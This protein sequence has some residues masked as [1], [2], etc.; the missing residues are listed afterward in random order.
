MRRSLLLWFGLLGAPAAW[1][2]QH[3]TGYALTEAACQEA[4]FDFPVDG[5]TIAVTAA[6]GVVAALAGVAAVATWR[7]TRDGGQR[8]ARKHFMATM[9]M[10]LTPLFLMIILMSGIGSVSVG[11]A[12]AAEPPPIVRPANA[13]GAGLFAANCA[14]CHGAEGQGRR[15]MGP[16]LR[17]VGAL[18]ADFYL[19]TGYMPLGDPHDQPVRG[20]VR[21]RE[22][23]LRALVDYVDS[24]G[25]GPPVPEVGR[26]DVSEGQELFTEHCAGCHQVVAEGGVVTSVRVPPLDRATP[27]Q[28]AQAVRL[29]PYVMPTF[30]ERD[31]TDA[32]LDSIVAY[33][34][35]AQRPEDDGGLGIGHLGP[36]P[37]GMVTW[38]VAALALVAV[39][40]AIGRRA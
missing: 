20:R 31:I 21:F 37:E 15:G 39:C 13:D 5:V 3:V 18:A 33:V 26:G 12:L 29:G 17:G 28:V 6:A 9:G 1:V 16:P 2:A 23:E 25:D 40:V 10:T 36:F 30:S 38:L 24:L 35:Y 27:V 32:E 7:A 34:E 8:T 11:C 19:R 22:A 14:R 4:G